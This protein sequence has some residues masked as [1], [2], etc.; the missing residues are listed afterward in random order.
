MTY[1]DI[2]FTV[3]TVP[4]SAAPRAV[5]DNP[6]ALCNV[7]RRAAAALEATIAT[8]PH[9]AEPGVYL[10]RHPAHRAQWWRRIARRDQLPVDIVTRNSTLDEQRRPFCDVYAVPAPVP[11]HPRIDPA[12][13]V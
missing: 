11:P 7:P 1:I 10:G 3:T 12:A 9:L 4:P 2:P 5:A 13:E 8:N 6:D